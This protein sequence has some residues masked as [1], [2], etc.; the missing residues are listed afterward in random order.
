MKSDQS[1]G[2]PELFRKGDGS[3]EQRHQQK[4]SQSEIPSGQSAQS[5]Q[6]DL[7]SILRSLEENFITFVK[8]ELK[9]INRILSSEGSDHP[10]FL[11]S[12]TEDKEGDKPERSSGHHTVHP[13]E[14]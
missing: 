8:N 7:P 6:P 14:H 13:E 12:Q 4:R 5:H 10:E 1:M 2:H 11:G 3:T 9:N